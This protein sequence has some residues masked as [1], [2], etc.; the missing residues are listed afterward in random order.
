MALNLLRVVAGAAGIVVG[1]QLL[2]NSGSQIA[3][4]WGVLEAIIGVMIVAIGTSLP[5]R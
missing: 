1:S 4:S 5:V 2:V 3:A